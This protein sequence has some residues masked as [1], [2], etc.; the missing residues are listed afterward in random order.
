MFDGT[1]VRGRVHMALL[2]GRLLTMHVSCPGWY[3]TDYMTV[4]THI[5]DTLK[6]I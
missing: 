4:Y 3:N 1:I 2:D 5:R 6:A